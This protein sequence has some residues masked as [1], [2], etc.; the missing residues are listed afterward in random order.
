[1]NILKINFMK[2]KY[3]LAINFIC[4]VFL[5]IKYVCNMVGRLEKSGRG[6][7]GGGWLISDF[8]NVQ[9]NNSK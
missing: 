7:G 5:K 9:E 3:S 6:A 1:M 2:Q 4:V 8:V